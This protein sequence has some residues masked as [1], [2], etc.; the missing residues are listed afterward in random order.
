MKRLCIIIALVNWPGDRH[1]EVAGKAHN[2]VIGI[3]EIG[4][5]Q[6]RGVDHSAAQ[7]CAAEIHLAQIGLEE[8]FFPEVK[9]VHIG[10]D[11]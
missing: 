7:V 3:A 2:I 4:P 11:L 10:A 5:L 1:L 8:L 6:L 9:T